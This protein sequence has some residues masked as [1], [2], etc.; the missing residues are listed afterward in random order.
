[1]TFGSRRGVGRIAH[2]EEA[3]LRD[4]PF[5]EVAHMLG[6]LVR[7]ETK[8]DRRAGLRR[9]AVRRLLTD[10]PR[11]DP[12]KIE[13]RPQNLLVER[14]AAFRASQ[15]ERIRWPDEGGVRELRP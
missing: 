4:V 1:M 15:W 5:D 11:C 14:R 9:N 10:V 2:D 7:H 6:C 3:L 12:A 8:V 13:R